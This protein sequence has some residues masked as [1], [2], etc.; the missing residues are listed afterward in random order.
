MNLIGVPR[1][2]DHPPRKPKPRPKRKR[3]HTYEV[4]P[5]QEVKRG[6][7]MAVGMSLFYLTVAFVGAVVAFL[8]G[9][10]LVAMFLSSL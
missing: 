5:F 1:P 3:K 4:H 6:C 9:F 7:W 10:P 8:L 2:P